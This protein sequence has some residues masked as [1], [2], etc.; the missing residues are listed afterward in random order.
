MHTCPKTEST[1]AGDVPH[2][3]GPILPAGAK[4]VL[5][6]GQPAARV[7]DQAVCVGKPDKVSQ[8]SA[9]VI[10]DGKQA[11]RLGD[12]SEHGGAIVAPCCPTVQIGP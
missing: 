5:I 2:V 10:I 9:T 7:D 3:G 1:P 6:A 4:T 11:A 8:G 12:Q